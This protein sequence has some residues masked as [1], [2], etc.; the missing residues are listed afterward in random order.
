MGQGSKPRTSP[1]QHWPSTGLTLALRWRSPPARRPP[2]IRWSR[3]PARPCDESVRRDH[4]EA[5]DLA[6]LVGRSTSTPCHS[7]VSRSSRRSP[8]P[9]SCSWGSDSSTSWSTTMAS[10]L[11]IWS[12][13]WSLSASCSWCPPRVRR[14]PTNYA[15]RCWRRCIATRWT[16]SSTSRPKSSSRPTKVPT[17]TIGSSGQR[18]RPAAESQ[19]SSSGSSRWCPHWWSR[20]ASWP[21]SLRSLRSSCQRRSSGTYRSPSSTCGTTERGTN[22]SSSSPRLSESGSISSTS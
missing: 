13:T 10:T 14:S 6:D 16:R 21:C 18:R 15:F 19:P 3:E 17:S 8:S 22:S 20:W 7:C 12:R 11:A 4:T 1:R 9:D 5:G 2:E